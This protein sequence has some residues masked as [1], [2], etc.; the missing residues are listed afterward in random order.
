MNASLVS[1]YMSLDHLIEKRGADSVMEFVFCDCYLIQLLNWE[2]LQVPSLLK[3]YTFF[4]Q[5][6][7]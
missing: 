2:H 4:P 6:I 7:Y 5:F 1:G 3:L